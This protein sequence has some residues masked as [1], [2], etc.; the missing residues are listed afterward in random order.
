MV[1]LIAYTQTGDNP[2]YLDLSDTSIKATYSSKE[3]QDVTQQKSDFTHNITLPFT[4]VNNDFFAHYYEVNVDGSF[5]AD[6]KA[7][8]SIY[9]D[10]NLIFD[11]YIQLVKVDTLNE[12]Y[13]AICFGDVA[14][15]ATEL[16]EDKLNDLDLSKYNHILTSLDVIS[17]WNGL[18]EY[19]GT[20]PDGD[21]ILYPIIDN[22]FNYHGN[23]LNTFDGAINVNDL[24][25]AIKVK[26]LLDE[27]VN[28]AGYTIN[29][30][31][32]NSTF[33]TNQYMTL[34]GE[35]EGVITDPPTGDTLDGFK[36]GK[37]STQNITP[38]ANDLLVLDNESSANGYYDTNSNWASSSYT[39]PYSGDYS[40]MIQL[41]INV[42]TMPS[43]QNN[44]RVHVNG[45]ASVYFIT[46]EPTATGSDV[47][48]FSF[49]PISLDASDVVTFKIA[50]DSTAVYGVFENLTINGAVYD[51]FAKLVEAPISYAGGVVPLGVGNNLLPK[52]K[53]VDFVKS[54]FAR[55]NLIVEIDKDTPKQLN[56]EPI[57]DFRDVGVSK[58]WTDKLDLSKS[59]IIEPTNK[60]RK[61]ELN[62]TDKEDE[63]RVNKLWQDQKSEVYNSYKYPFY[64]DFGSGELKVPTIFSSFVPKKVYNNIMFIAQHFEWVDGVIKAV[65]T[66]PK[67]F[68]YS[69]KKQLPPASNFNL[70]DGDGT[71]YPKTEYPF[72]HHYSMAGDL[73]TETDTDIRFKAGSVL[74]QSSLVETQT[75]SDVYNV[76]WKRYLDNIYNKEARIQTAY[77]YL[78]SQDIADFKY[79]DKIFIKDSYWFINKINSYAIGVGNST[80][81]ELI[82]A[83]ESPKL[84][85]C[86]LTVS[87]SNLN[88]TT[89]WIDADGVS[90]Q[91]TAACCEAEGYTFT[92]SK[93]YWN[94]LVSSSDLSEP[95]VLYD[96][97]D[98]SIVIVGQNSTSLKSGNTTTETEF[99]GVIK[100][101][102]EGDPKE[103]YALS[104]ND[105][106]EQTDWRAIPDSGA[107][108]DKIDITSAQYQALGSTPITLVA[109]PG[110]GKVI[111]PVSIYIYARRTSTE[112]SS[113]D[114]YLGDTTSTSSGGY[115][116][117]IRDFMNNETGSR[118]YIAP[119]TKGEIA[120]GSLANRRLQLYSNGAFNGLIELTVYV[121]YQIMDI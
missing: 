34:G 41:A 108:T 26:T 95:P 97:V 114:L 23:T 82:K 10:S 119:P 2:I 100:K 89:N 45:V 14:N 99:N 88:G 120:Q 65:K 106:L 29:S 92:G 35:V 9:V 8:C 7:S 116:T 27:V 71:F 17:S 79:N 63:D 118:T 105:T 49:P 5:R 24:R 80:K 90:T 6:V 77:F 111:I 36:V 121:T 43:V 101:I 47:F 4:Q 22:G 84:E 60:Y 68:Y 69:G 50:A 30:T 76:Y 46:F 117:Y 53:Q 86:N 33:F 67:L 12:N 62:L 48:V 13:T 104:W 72:C 56:I 59:V 44:V 1:Q 16:G 20:Q 21:E 78:T 64:G 115:Y 37:T 110:S 83:L 96:G 57:Q 87:T 28:K 11:G 31:F 109:A 55:Y 74:N 102:G 75:G 32:L 91:P 54:I 38:F 94:T 39:A 81:V 15:L 113:R 3:I 18:T 107:K 73:V 58:D 66:K 42:S 70:T 61:A 51:T 93:C 103:G 98:T 25:P 112:T 40:F 85:L 52:D 19:I